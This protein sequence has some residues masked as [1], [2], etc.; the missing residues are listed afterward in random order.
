[1]EETDMGQKLITHSCGHTAVHNLFGPGA[2]RTRKADWLKTTLCSDCYQA[3]QAI[4]QQ[5]R[6]AAA[7]EANTEAGLPALEGTPKQIA[8]AETIRA[9]AKVGLD[10]LIARAMASTSSDVDKATVVEDA[11]FIL[12]QTRTSYWIDNRQLGAD[13]LLNLR[14]NARIAA[15]AMQR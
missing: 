1:M 10:A 5:Q 8:W 11:K 9:K 14:Q 15:Q 3:E 13:G 7:V 4:V 2:E 12:R 6:H